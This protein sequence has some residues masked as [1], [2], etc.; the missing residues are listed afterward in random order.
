MMMALLSASF[1]VKPLIRLLDVRVM[2]IEPFQLEVGHPPFLIFEV[3]PQHVNRR[4]P[5]YRFINA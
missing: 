5:E 4:N 3:L 2:R 1:F